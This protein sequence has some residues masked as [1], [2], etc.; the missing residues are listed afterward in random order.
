MENKRKLTVHADGEIAEDTTKQ[1]HSC[2][3]I[4]AA[5]IN[6]NILKLEKSLTIIVSTLKVCLYLYFVIAE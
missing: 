6:Q 1:F 3:I 2:P 5:F 4:W